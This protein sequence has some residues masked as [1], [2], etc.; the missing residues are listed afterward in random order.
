MLY[1]F[2]LDR[3][4]DAM[5]SN[6]IVCAALKWR[7]NQTVGSRRVHVHM[8]HCPIAGDANVTSNGFRLGLEAQ[9]LYFSFGS[10]RFDLHIQGLSSKP[11]PTYFLRATAC[12]AKRVFATAEASFCPSVCPS[13]RLSHCCIVSKRRNLGSWN[14]HCELPQGL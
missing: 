5:E 4:P 11:R 14:L 13:V 9:C 6:V 8:P 1:W 10:K 2:L 12:N 7:K 3:Q